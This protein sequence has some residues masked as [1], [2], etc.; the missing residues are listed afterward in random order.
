MESFTAQGQHDVSQG[1]VITCLRTDKTIL[2]NLWTLSKLTFQVQ[3]L[4][5]ETRRAINDSNAKHKSMVYDL[6]S[7]Y[8]FQLV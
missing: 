5:Q 8:S 2:T 7:S 4:H 6:Y 1:H 3:G